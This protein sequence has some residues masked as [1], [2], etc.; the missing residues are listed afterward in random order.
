[1][2]FRFE[3]YVLLLRLTM[4]LSSVATFLF[5]VA[6]CI[7]Q[8]SSQECRYVTVPVCDNNDS[9]TASTV[10]PSKGEKGD[11]GFS[12]KLGPRGE[13]GSKGNVGEKGSK[14]NTAD[15]EELQQY[16]SLKI[17]GMRRKNCC[18]FFSYEYLMK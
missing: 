8:G 6:G 3:A 9:S 18:L 15:V 12:G 11:R 10:V 4:A 17:D 1:M 16:L 13:T 5:I 14:G 2:I 7:G